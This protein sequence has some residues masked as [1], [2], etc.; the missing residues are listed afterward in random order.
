MWPILLPEG[1]KSDQKFVLEIQRFYNNF[2]WKNLIEQVKTIQ[3]KK[4]VSTGDK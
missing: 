1:N 3:G 4:L 2:D